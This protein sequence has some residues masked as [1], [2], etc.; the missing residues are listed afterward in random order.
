MGENVLT[1]TDTLES[2][3]ANSYVQDG[4]NSP[5]LT[6][7]NISFVTPEME[8]QSQNCWFDGIRIG[9]SEW[10]FKK[11]M[12]FEWKAD[13]DLVTQYFNLRGE[14]STDIHVYGKDFPLGNYTH[15]L[16]Y[17]PQSHGIIKSHD[18]KLIIFMVQY[19]VEKFLELIKDSNE[20]LQHFGSLITSGYPCAF[21]PENL[22]ID[23]QL[24]QTIEDIR[25]CPYTG[26]I[27]QMYLFSKCL[28]LLVLQADAYHRNRADSHKIIKTDYDKE[29][30]VFAREYLLEHMDAPP[31]LAELSRIAGINLFKLKNG[32]KEMFG[33][34][35]FGYLGDKRLEMAVRE[36]AAK[37]KSIN[38]I[39]LLTGYSSVQHFNKAFK[40]KFGVTP[41]RYK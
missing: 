39:A 18:S 10:N 14:V 34:T 31:S 26:G 4:Y 7:K 5:G 21:S 17:A 36:L 8:L 22:Y 23:G 12:H 11:D 35:V 29:R 25:N 1:G 27:R 15:N 38:D 20:S 9:Y 2:L 16:I 40:K 24:A 30:I 3:F 32:F 6:E 19:K 28:E 41:G 33:N 37:E 13:L